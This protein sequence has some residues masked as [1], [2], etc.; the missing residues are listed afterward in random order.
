MVH[1][2][3]LPGAPAYEN[4]SIDVI[5]ERAVRGAEIYEENEVDGVIVENMWDLPYYSGASRIPPE[6]IV[7]HAVVTTLC[8]VYA[9]GGSTMFTA[10]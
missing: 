3:P 4:W 10:F 5:V 2:L 7:A 8:L 9:P 1:L 6:E